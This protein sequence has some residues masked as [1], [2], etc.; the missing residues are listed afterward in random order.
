MKLRLRHN[1]SQREKLLTQNCGFGSQWFTI[2]LLTSHAI[3]QF[4]VLREAFI[5]LTASLF[6]QKLPKNDNK[7][8]WT[9]HAIEKMRYYR[10]SESLVKRVI[11]FPKRTEKAIAPKTIGAMQPK[12][13]VKNPREVWVMYRPATDVV[14]AFGKPRQITDF[15]KKAMSACATPEAASY[16]EVATKAESARRAL[17]RQKVKIISAWIYPGVTK[18]GDPIPVPEDMLED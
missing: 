18:P 10:L 8:V 16:A 2:I 9:M 14:P 11:R 13:T 12:G 4:W 5:Y 15:N 1:F 7:Y 17:G 3:T 6:M